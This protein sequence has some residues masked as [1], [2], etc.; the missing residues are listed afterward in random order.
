MGISFGGVTIWCM[1][2]L[3]L[4]GASDMNHFNQMN[5]TYRLDLTLISLLSAM[6]LTSVGVLLVTRD[7]SFALDRMDIEA[8]F[9]EAAKKLSITDIR[10]IPKRK[11]IIWRRL[12]CNMNQL[13]IAALFVAGA[14]CVMHYMGMMSMVIQGYISRNAGV[15]AASVILAYIVSCIGLWLIFRLL[16]LFPDEEI[17]SRKLSRDCRSCKCRALYRNCSC[18][19]EL[20]QKHDYY[21]S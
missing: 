7:R 19:N 20:R 17:L 3:A 14:V 1:H 10:K 6:V 13:C 9:V 8:N 16:T 5:V 4:T 18:K 12:F 2:Y 15:V 11:T 21:R